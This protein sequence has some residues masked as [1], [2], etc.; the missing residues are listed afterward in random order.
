MLKSRLAVQ[1]TVL[2]TLMVPAALGQQITVYS[3]GTVAI[4]Q[5]KHLTAYVPL[6]VTTVNWSVNGIIGGNS[7][8]G[9]VSTAGLYAAPAVVPANNAVT[10]AATSTA[11]AMK[12]GTVTITVT[13][14]P[15]YLWSISPTSVPVGPFTISLNGANFGANSVVNFGGAPL[16]TTLLS[17][18]GLRATGAATTTQVGTKVS[19]TVTN[20]GLG[21]TTSSVVNLSITAAAP[22][23]VSVAP[24]SVGVPASTTLQ[25][26]A[27][28]TG[29]V[30][31][32]VAWSVN[33]I[34]GGNSTV[35]T[36][37][38]VGLYTAPAAV[39]NP[40]NVTIQA[41]STASPSSVG[42]AVVTVQPPAPPPVTVTIA[43][44]NVTMA[45][46]ATQLFIATVTNSANTSVTWSING[47]VGGN[48]A[49]GTISAAGMYTAPAVAP[50]PASVAV[51]ATSAASPA[52]SASTTASIVGP[53]NP[54][55][56]QGT[57]N[58]SAARFLQQATFGPTPA[59]VAH[60]NQVGFNA[61]LNEQFNT[62]ETQIVD[63]GGMGGGALQSQYV[64]RLSQAPDQLRQRVAYAL[65]QIIVISMNKNIYPNEVVPYLQI[66]SRNAFGNYRTLLGEISVSSQMG[67]YLDLAKSTKPGVGGG[68]NENYAREVMQL[69]SIGLYR[70]NPDGSQQLD[71]QGHPI[72]TYNQTT[73]QQ[74]ALALTGWV[75]PNNAWE[76]F[77][78]PMVPLETN[79][80]TTQKTLLGCTLPAGQNTTA[81]MNGLLDCL[82]NHPNVG[83][84]IA[85]R[86]IRSLVTS[87]PSPAY[88]QRIST[89]FNNNGAGVRGDL[90]AV[91]QAILTDAEARNDAAPPTSGRLKDPIFH[92]VSFVR[93]L[94]GSIS[95]SNGL[96]WM[97][98]RLAQGP[99]T[100]PSVFSFYSPLYRIPQSPY[101][102]PEFQ[103][104]TPTESILR[105]NFLWEVISNPAT[106]M[107]RDLSPFTAVAGNTVQLI[108]AVDQAL[109]YG[110][111]PQQMRQSLA[112]AIVAQSDNNSRAQTALYLTALSGFYAVQY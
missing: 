10:V 48:A 91:I 99:L 72:P 110:R 24:V 31:A 82:F 43:P 44:V 59:D 42:T 63:P 100:P 37:S 97:F 41:T 81:D 68:A 29:S 21:G 79:H 15:V 16:A 102:G 45:P 33:A 36:I 55:S 26:T 90:R 65:S 13:Q 64:S 69:F 19:I 30:N 67:K 78:G 87:N 47:V 80:D 7:T 22:L 23:T 71:G 4:G 96:S 5:T 60:V 108:D 75:Y 56:S 111:M 109:L 9:T 106:D 18:T 66:L 95:P 83:P 3:S 11:D 39:P 77:S 88:I 35:G 28:V 12:F 101:F 57:A 54:G 107:T 105:G 14:P 20:G 94:N 98:S 32:A 104:Y 25:F 53:P 73:I 92:V 93:A 6:A 1:F 2:A 50:N 76:D 38:S 62:P 46:S 34:T 17:P 52:S 86:L 74:V 70:L 84:F 27:T 112:N 58:L 40:A 8:F 103:I 85:T 61:W 49:V 51:K 89:V